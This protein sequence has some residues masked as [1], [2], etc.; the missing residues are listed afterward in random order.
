MIGV[1]PHKGPHTAAVS[2]AAEE[3]LCGCGCGRLGTAAC[4]VSVP[5]QHRVPLQGP[6]GPSSAP[7]RSDDPPSGSSIVLSGAVNLDQLVST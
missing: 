3:L 1:D 4:R 5:A 7:P 2:G 6:P